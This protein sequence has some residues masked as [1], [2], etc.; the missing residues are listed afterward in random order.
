MVS[1]AVNYAIAIN[2][3][4]VPL[5]LLFAGFAAWTKGIPVVAVILGTLAVA[6]AVRGWFVRRRLTDLK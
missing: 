4:V 1:W 2:L 3:V 5:I 6:Q